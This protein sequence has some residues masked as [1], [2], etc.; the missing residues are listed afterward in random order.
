MNKFARCILELFEKDI[1]ESPHSDFD[2]Q[3]VIKDFCTQTSI[4]ELVY[5][6]SS[7]RLQTERYKQLYLGRVQVLRHQTDRQTNRLTL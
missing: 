4:D 7:L 2:I 1:E 6:V 5:V 3:K